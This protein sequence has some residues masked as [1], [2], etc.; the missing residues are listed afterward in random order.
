MACG[1]GGPSFPITP[2]PGL[3]AQG[4]A[5]YQT[6]CLQCHGD[7]QGQGRQPNAP[8]HT[9]QGHTWHHPDRLLF[10]WILDGPPMRTTMPAFRGTLT[11]EQVIAVLAYIKTFWPEELREQ[12][13][14][15]SLQFEHQL[16]GIPHH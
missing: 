1:G 11:E 13:A 10:Q 12:Q 5:V 6:H 7:A 3:V 14:D 4:Q 16:Q 2:T 9:A 8:P 15:F